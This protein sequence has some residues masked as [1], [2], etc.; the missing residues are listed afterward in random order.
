MSAV[1]C[2]MSQ[3]PV[4]RSFVVLQ[5]A[6]RLQTRVF[7]NLLR[8]STGAFCPVTIFRLSTPRACRSFAIVHADTRSDV[9]NIVPSS[10]SATCD[11][12]LFVEHGPCL[13][14]GTLSIDQAYCNTRVKL[15]S[16]PTATGQLSCIASHEGRWCPLVRGIR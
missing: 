8:R 14:G 12:S 13:V 10:V 5:R 3:I 11:H 6:T 1:F 7:M 4:R 15:H 2:A 16:G 9:L